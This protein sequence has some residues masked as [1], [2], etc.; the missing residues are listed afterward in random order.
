MFFWGVFK[1]TMASDTLSCCDQLHSWDVLLD[2]MMNQ[3]RMTDLN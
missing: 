1:R 3:I 2:E